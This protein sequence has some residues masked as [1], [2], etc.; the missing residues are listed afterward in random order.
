[1][2]RGLRL[3]DRRWKYI[4]KD[5]VMALASSAPTFLISSKISKDTFKYILH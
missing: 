3:V 1:M 5:E 4:S 2:R